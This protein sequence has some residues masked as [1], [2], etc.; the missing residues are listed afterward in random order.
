M[1]FAPMNRPGVIEEILAMPTL[2]GMQA[3]ATP[4]VWGQGG[5]Q[6]TPDQLAQERSVAQ[7]L[8]Q[9]DYSPVGHWTQGLGRVLDNFTGSQDLKRLD[10]EE[11]QM[12]ADRLAQITSMAGEANADLA[13]GLSS[14]DP[15]VQALATQQMQARMP[16]QTK[17]LEFQQMLM[18]A[19]YLPGTP[20]YQAEA[21]KL[22]AARN[23]Q[24]ITANLPGGGFYG[25]PQSSFMTALTGGGGQSS[26]PAMPEWWNNLTPEEQGVIQR[27]GEGRSANRPQGS[28][29]S[30]G[31][32]PGQVVDG[33]RFKGGNPNDRSS[34]E[35]AR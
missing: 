24:F 25:G 4:F 8:A 9:S 23:D 21:R 13:P 19:G 3:P 17:P 1:T 11:G 20:E 27:Q 22:L 10:R 34:W 18:D 5:A 32:Q 29:L 26:G 2:P 15:V 16:K 14:A 35:Q 12:N 28:P 6:L 30:G 31:P 33:Y 7:A